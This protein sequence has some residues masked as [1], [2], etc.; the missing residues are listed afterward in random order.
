M[1]L[2]EAVEITSRGPTGRVP[3]HGAHIRIN[4]QLEEV[5]SHFRIYSTER[6]VKEVD[7]GVLVDSPAR[8]RGKS[9]QRAPPWPLS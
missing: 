9:D 1:S 8:Q 5:F 7:V 2:D 6:I 3:E 4:S